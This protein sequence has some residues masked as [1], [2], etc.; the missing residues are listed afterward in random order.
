M[1]QAGCWVADRLKFWSQA[2]DAEVR[3]EE[4]R[5]HGPVSANGTRAEQIARAV[6]H[7]AWRLGRSVELVDGVYAEALLEGL[8]DIGSQAVAKRSVD[9]VRLVERGGRSSEQVA[10]R[11]ADIVQDSCARAANLGPEGL[12]GELAAQT[13]G[14]ASLQDGRDAQHRGRAVV[15]WHGRVDDFVLEC[16]PRRHEPGRA[17]A[18]APGHDGRLGQPRGARRVDEHGHAVALLG[19]ARR[20]RE[21]RWRQGQDRVLQGAVEEDGL[22]MV[23]QRSCHKLGLALGVDE[24]QARRARRDGVCK[25]LAR[26]VVVDKRGLCADAPEA[27]PDPDKDAAVGKVHGDNVVLLHALAQ[28]PRRILEHSLVRLGIRPCLA[29]EDDPGVGCARRLRVRLERIEEVQP[30]AALIQGAAHRRTNQRRQQCIVVAYTVAGVEI[31]SC[32]GGGCGGQH[33]RHDCVVACVGQL[34]AVV[35]WVCLPGMVDVAQL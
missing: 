21:A 20:I 22:D 11:L 6:E 1:D 7:A 26:Q 30:V 24:H 33:I 2:G 31:C 19:P 12:V 18:L 32:R 34:G 13:D 3:R 17:R 9:V 35:P 10:T 8:P 25:R 4:Q 15:E 27:K 23:S 29:V 28:Q 5:S 14:A 16:Q